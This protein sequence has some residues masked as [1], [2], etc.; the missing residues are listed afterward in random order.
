MAK[1]EVTG[2]NNSLVTCG[3]RKSIGRKTVKRE[4]A[5][6]MQNSKRERQQKEIYVKCKRVY[7]INYNSEK[8]HS[9]HIQ[10]AATDYNIS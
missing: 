9:I 2:Y 1:K 7:K 10:E 3:A 4:L 5:R 8:H 6:E